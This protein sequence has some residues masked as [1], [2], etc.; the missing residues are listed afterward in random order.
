M[1]KEEQNILRIRI[2][3]NILY[4]INREF[5]IEYKQ[6]DIYDIIVFSAKDNIRFAVKVGSSTYLDSV[7]F[8]RYIQRLNLSTFMKEFEHIPIVL[9]CVNESTEEARMGIVLGW[10]YLNPVIYKRVSLKNINVQNW[11][12]FEDHIKAMDSVIRVFSKRVISIIKRIII[13]KVDNHERNYTAEIIYLRTFFN[14]Y[15]MQQKE[16]VD[17]KEDFR[18]NIYGIPENEFPSDILDKDL[19]EVVQQEYP[20]AKVKSSLM[21]DN[22]ALRDFEQEIKKFHFHNTVTFILEPDAK[23]FEQMK[24]YLYFLK[25]Q[26]NLYVSSL[27][28]KELFGD[29]YLSK[30]IPLNELKKTFEY[31]SQIRN[32]VINP[33]NVLNMLR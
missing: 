3:A 31:Y 30:N 18:R 8:A 16:I 11:L 15:K 29:M 32:T 23:E 9:M 12:I 2:A 21:L 22:F 27:K 4:R 1:K 28:E 19:L 26:F 20:T 10:K 24:D 13:N 5:T 14:E 33:D 6:L 25:F 7:A 17:E